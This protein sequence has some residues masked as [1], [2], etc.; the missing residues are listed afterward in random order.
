MPSKHLESFRS[1]RQMDHSPPRD[2]AVR[3]ADLSEDLEVDLPDGDDKDA[4]LSLLLEARDV[5][6]RASQSLLR[7]RVDS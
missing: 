1:F 3:F 6:V 5:A 2:V 4:C 7:G